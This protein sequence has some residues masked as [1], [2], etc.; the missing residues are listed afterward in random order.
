MYANC[1]FFFFFQ[2]EQ[3]VMQITYTEIRQDA[4]HCKSLR[5]DLPSEREDGKM[6][7]TFQALWL[8]VCKISD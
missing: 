1:L 5:Q 6:G 2:L 3:L 8:Y 4:Y 7:D